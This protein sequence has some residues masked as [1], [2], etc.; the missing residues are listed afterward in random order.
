MC[1]GKSCFISS[2]WLAVFV[3]EQIIN[4]KATKTSSIALPDI[5]KS[6]YE[7][8]DSTL[9]WGWRL[10]TIIHVSKIF[11][12]KRLLQNEN[13]GDMFSWFSRHCEAIA[14]QCL[15]NHEN[16][17]PQWIMTNECMEVDTILVLIHFLSKHNEANISVRFWIPRKSHMFTP[18]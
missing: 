14:S 16:M 1:F 12:L 8:S 18:Y 2:T 17:F 4:N 11:I 7:L 10:G 5:L 13:L 3:A 15:E 9:L 6:H